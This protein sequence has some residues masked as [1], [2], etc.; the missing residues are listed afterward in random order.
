MHTLER[1]NV[2]INDIN[3]QAKKLEREKKKAKKVEGNY[4]DQSR[5]D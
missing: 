3:F 1:R 5:N 4:K 2:K